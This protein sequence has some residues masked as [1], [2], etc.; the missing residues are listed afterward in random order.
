MNNNYNNTND[1]I[2][3]NFKKG[4]ILLNLKSYDNEQQIFEKYRFYNGDYKQPNNQFIGDQSSLERQLQQSVPSRFLCGQS[5][6]PDN[7]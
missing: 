4:C 7:M 5:F 2:K 3:Q 6:R 1:T